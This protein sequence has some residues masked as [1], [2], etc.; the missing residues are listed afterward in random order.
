MSYSWA[1]NI[2]M[3]H[4]WIIPRMAART[5]HGGNWVSCVMSFGVPREI[6]ARFLMGGELDSGF[7]QEHLYQNY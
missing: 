1:Q 4:R 6:K 5:S 2:S 3:F 7:L